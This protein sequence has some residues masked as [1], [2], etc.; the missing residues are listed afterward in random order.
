MWNKTVNGN[1][2]PDNSAPLVQLTLTPSE[3]RYEDT[4]VTVPLSCGSYYQRAPVFLCKYG[5]WVVLLTFYAN[6]LKYRAKVLL[7]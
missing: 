1:F 5:G 6:Q 4:C 3:G 7:E 2:T